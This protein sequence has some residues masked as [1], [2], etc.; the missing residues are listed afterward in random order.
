VVTT[1][2]A[3]VAGPKPARLSLDWEE[4]ERGC[5]LARRDVERDEDFRPA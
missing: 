1:I 3:A 2:R 4:F 5:E